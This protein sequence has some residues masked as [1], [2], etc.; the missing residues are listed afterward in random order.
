MT[1][2]IE[3][4]CS[5]YR[6]LLSLYP[7]DVNQRFGIQMADTFA[8]QLTDAWQDRRLP[9]VLEVWSLTLPEFLLIALPRQIAR[10]ILVLPIVSLASTSAIFFSLI[11]S[12]HNPLVLNAWYHKFVGG[13][14]R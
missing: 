2:F 7:P 1:R 5:V 13:I 6:A 8:Q 12:L 9:G 3:F 10:P 11:W 14:C 4:S